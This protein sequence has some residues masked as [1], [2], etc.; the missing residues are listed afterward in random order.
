M[1]TQ[2][3]DD[4]GER[5]VDARPEDRVDCRED[6]GESVVPLDDS[7]L[8]GVDGAGRGPAS[9]PGRLDESL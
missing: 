7:Q 9:L 1:T 2:S 8:K 5:P 4:P 3:D 6:K